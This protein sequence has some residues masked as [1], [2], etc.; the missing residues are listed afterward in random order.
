MRIL[1]INNNDSIGGAARASYN[2][3]KGLC[4]IGIDSKMLVGTKTTNDYGVEG[5]ENKKTVVM[6]HSHRS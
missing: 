6:H 4:D 3:Y 5:P 2:L 1:T